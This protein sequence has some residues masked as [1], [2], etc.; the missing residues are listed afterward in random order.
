MVDMAND[1]ESRCSVTLFVWYCAAHQVILIKAFF[2]YLDY[3]HVSTKY[4]VNA[5]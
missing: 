2:P 3:F 5:K 1:P 4:F